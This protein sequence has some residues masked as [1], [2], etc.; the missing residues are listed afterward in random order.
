MQRPEGVSLSFWQDEAQL[1]PRYKALEGQVDADI[2]VIGGGITGTACAL[3]LARDDQHVI[4]LERQTVA[5]GASGRNGGFLL[6]G[7]VETYDRAIALFGH[8]RARRLYAFSVANNVMV[9]ALIDELEARRWPT[10]YRHT[11]SL[12]LADSPEE[13]VEIRAAARLLNEDG[14]ATE[15]VDETRLPKRL[16]GHYMG[17]SFHPTDGE[18]QP[19]KLVSGLAKLAQEAGAIIH[20]QTPALSLQENKD[21]VVIETPAGVVHAQKA[22]L[23]TN[24]WLDDFLPAPAESAGEAERVVTPTRGQMLA[25]EPIAEKLFECPIYAHYGYQY[26]RQLPD[27]RL[28]VGGWR[29]HAPD[30]DQLDPTQAPTDVVQQH[31]DD[32][33]YKTVGLPA[34][35]EITHRWAGLMAFSASGLPIVGRAPGKQHIFLSGGYTGH[36]NAMAVRCAR[37][38]ADLACGLANTDADLF[39]PHQSSTKKRP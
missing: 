27:G 7:T 3:W 1:A 18:I 15:V 10:G 38:V 6:A 11:G 2:V 35:T 12:R 37:L 25:T 19:A 8:E 31:L 9:R 28:I 33:V 30:R 17:G 21:G 16:R 39:A 13:L 29:D 23:A 20:E 24:A 36:G 14:W 22:I 32:F 34:S 5:H 4:L 26:W